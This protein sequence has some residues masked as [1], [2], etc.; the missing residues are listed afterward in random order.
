MSTETTGLATL[1]RAVNDRARTTIGNP[2]NGTYAVSIKNTD[3]EE[4]GALLRILEELGIEAQLN[5]KNEKHYVALYKV[6]ALRRLFEMTELE[7]EE[8]RRT[9]L[10]ELVRS[11]EPMPERLMRAI[12]Q[13]HNWNRMSFEAIAQLMNQKGM[14]DGMGGRGWTVK[15][16]RA[17]YRRFTA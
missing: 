2:W 15:K 3:A 12:Q 6:D 4:A 17:A 16:V 1:L 14:V 7:L 10:D 5:S 11:R 8:R 13:K 9:A